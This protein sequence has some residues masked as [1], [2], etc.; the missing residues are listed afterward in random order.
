MTIASDLE[1]IAT[2]VDQVANLRVQT[3]YGKAN[4]ACAVVELD[5]V[6]APATHSGGANYLVRVLLLV[7]IGDFRNS[8]DRIY[9]FADPAG[10]VSTS[11]LTALL[12]YANAGE[13]SFDGPGLVEYGGQTYGGGVFTVEVFA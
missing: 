5:R 11:V 12:S 10:T 7:Q 6:T 3:K 1:D 2:A 13:V 8:L 9:A 4:P